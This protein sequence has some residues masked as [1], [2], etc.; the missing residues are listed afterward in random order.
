[1]HEQLAKD[2]AFNIVGG[3]AVA[4]TPVV[5]PAPPPFVPRTE[6]S[7]PAA[8][9]DKIAGRYEF[10]PGFAL[11]ITRDSEFLY[12]QAQREGVPGVGRPG[13]SLLEQDMGAPVGIGLVGEVDLR[14]RHFAP[15]TKSG[16]GARRERDPSRPVETES[17]IEPFNST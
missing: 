7:L 12:A 4:P 1:V 15:H 14:R 6:I 16:H 3:Q 11:A 5:P 10:G 13:G 8:D 2:L 17:T 9:L